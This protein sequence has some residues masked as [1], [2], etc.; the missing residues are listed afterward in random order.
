[1]NL[2]KDQIEQLVSVVEEEL[3]DMEKYQYLGYTKTLALE[4]DGFTVHVVVVSDD[5][6]EDEDQQ[7]E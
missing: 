7:E 6:V 5:Y 4:V 2:E 3:T 1:M